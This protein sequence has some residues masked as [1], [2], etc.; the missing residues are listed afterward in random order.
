MHGQISPISLATGGYDHLI[1]MWQPSDGSLLKTFQHT[2]SQVNS[3]AFSRD[4]SALIAGGFGRLRLYDVYAYEQA[5]PKVTVSEFD[6]NVNSVGF[7]ETGSW[8]FAGGE[9]KSVKII[10]RRTI[11]NDPACITRVMNMPGS[12]TSIVIHPDQTALLV[13]TEKGEIHVW[14]LRNEKTPVTTIIPGSVGDA[15]Y[16]IDLS[17]D[18]GCLAAVNSCGELIVW[19]YP[20]NTEYLKTLVRFISALFIVPFQHRSKVHSSYGLRVLFSPD[21]TLLATCGA[22]SKF[23][24]VNTADYNVQFSKQDK[25]ARSYW[26]WDCA[27]SADSRYLLTAS[28]DALARLW[29]IEKGLEILKYIGHKK[30]ITCMAFMDQTFEQT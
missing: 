4:R 30:P 12:V 24:V 16:S 20:K 5:T 13:A 25:T 6:K 3:L 9:D 29:N 28:S 17:T 19:N 8:V 26:V 10:D 21:G 22:D 11:G 15:I 7:N 23:N 1:N 18:G 27:F 14:D 2:E